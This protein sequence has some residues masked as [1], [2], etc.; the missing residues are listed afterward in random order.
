MNG[1][2]ILHHGA[3]YVL[4]TSAG[5]YYNIGATTTD[6]DSNK[7]YTIARSLPVQLGSGFEDL[8]L[9]SNGKNYNYYN[10]N[11]KKLTNGFIQD[12]MSNWYYFD[13][14]GNMIKNAKFTNIT[15]GKNRGTYFFMSNGVSFR[16]GLLTN[17]S[18]T[19]YFD[20]NGRM[21]KGKTVKSDAYTYTLN[22]S[23]YLTS[24]KYT[25]ASKNQATTKNSLGALKKNNKK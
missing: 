21:V 20:K 1:T 4:R 6:K 22:K 3:G 23:G 14:N 16:G 7:K 19:Y 18:R 11:R 9:V 13:K 10:D 2:N 5:K 15:S 8:G 17:G 25:A 12:S 24:E